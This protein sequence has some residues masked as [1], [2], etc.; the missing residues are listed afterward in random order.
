MLYLYI[1]VCWNVGSSHRVIL[2]ISMDLAQW[3]KRLLASRFV[4]PVMWPTAV[5]MSSSHTFLFNTS[6]YRTGLKGDLVK[7]AKCLDETI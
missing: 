6:C 5:S 7:I 1:R 4:T 3:L 2:S